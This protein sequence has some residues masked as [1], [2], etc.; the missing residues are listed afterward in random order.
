[1][2]VGH[3]GL[4]LAGKRIAPRVSLGTWF[5]SVQL[6]DLLWPLFLLLGREHVRIT[7]GYTRMSPLDFYDYPITHSLAG[8]VLWG[9]LLCG[10]YLLATRGRGPGRR[11]IALLLAAG[12]VSHWFLDLVVHREDLPVLPAIGPYLGFGLWNVPAATLA[13]ELALFGAGILLYLRATRARDGAG[14]W[15]LAALLGLLL[16]LWL[17]A[18]FGPPPPDEGIVAWSAMALWL[19]VPWAAWVDRHREPVAG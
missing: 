1:M 2:F 13:L 5:L 14:R 19:L 4:G 9:L 8:A 7:P 11:R 12:V 10:L 16:L 3:F 17:G 15:G 18:A 6:L